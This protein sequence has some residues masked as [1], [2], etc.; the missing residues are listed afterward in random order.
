MFLDNL[1]KIKNK[2]LNSAHF[3]TIFKTAHVLD[4]AEKTEIFQFSW[5]YYRH[6]EGKN[7]T[8]V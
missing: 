8:S 7:Y 6:T 5:T 3:L 4:M 2:R 1:K